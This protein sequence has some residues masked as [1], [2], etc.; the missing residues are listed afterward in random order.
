M[1]QAL[2]D[3][4][5]EKAKSGSEEELRETLKDANELRRTIHSINLDYA[6]HIVIDAIQ[7]R[8]D[9]LVTKYG[10]DAEKFSMQKL[11]ELLDSVAK[12]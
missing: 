3:L 8:V 11:K 6:G 9:E 7:P 5:V 4:V 2:I 10:L 12:E 1:D